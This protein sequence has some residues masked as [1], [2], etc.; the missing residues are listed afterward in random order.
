MLGL[1]L[2]LLLLLHSCH[3]LGLRLRRLPLRLDRQAEPALLHEG[4]HMIT[5]LRSAVAFEFAK[6]VLGDRH[7]VELGRKTRKVLGDEGAGKVAYLRLH[8]G[9]AETDVACCLLLGLL[10]LALLLLLL[11]MVLLVLLLLLLLLLMLLSGGGG[12]GL[13]LLLL[14]S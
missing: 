13:L 5:R 4:E 8:H 10:L 11:R 2:L 9:V 7:A 3:V 14:L 12:G 6:L 1:L